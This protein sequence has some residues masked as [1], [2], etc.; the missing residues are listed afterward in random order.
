MISTVGK[1]LD[2]LADKITQFVLILCLVLKYP[3]LIPLM[4]LFVIKE[5][6]QLIAGYLTMRKG[7]MLTGA[8]LTGKISTAVLF[9]SLILLVMFPHLELMYIRM[10]TFVDSILLLISFVHYAI[11]YFTHSAMIQ[12]LETSENEENA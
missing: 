12:S 3:A 9:I 6:F 7:R 10:I 11:T 8:L 2:P 4:I 5:L 1:I